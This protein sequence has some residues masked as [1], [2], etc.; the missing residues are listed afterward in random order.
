MN[1]PTFR[2]KAL[3]FAAVS[4]VNNG[5]FTASYNAA[6]DAVTRV[7]GMKLADSIFHGPRTAM[8]QGRRVTI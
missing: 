1:K 8:N 7:A 6:S 5:G 4:Y 2:E 3:S